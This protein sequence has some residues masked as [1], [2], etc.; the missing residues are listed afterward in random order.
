MRRRHVAVGEGC[1]DDIEHL[2]LIYTIAVFNVG[3][4]TFELDACKMNASRIYTNA[5]RDSR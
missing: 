4:F 1:Q 3:H 2:Y 5:V